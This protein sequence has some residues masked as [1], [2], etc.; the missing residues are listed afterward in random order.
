MFLKILVFMRKKTKIF[1]ND[2]LLSNN[3]CVQDSF[4]KRFLGLMFQFKPKGH[5]I[6]IFKNAFWI[7]SFFVFFSFDAIF[8]DD[9][10]KIIAYKF[11][12]PPFSIL[13]PIFGAKYVLEFVNGCPRVKIG[14]KMYIDE[15]RH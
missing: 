5:K 10:F 9:D 14:D 12:I 13:K 15:Y 3:A 11:N 7:H 1:L 6:L 2:E 8:L 4:L